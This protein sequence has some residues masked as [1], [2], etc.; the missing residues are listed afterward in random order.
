MACAS[1]QRSVS[2]RS[3]AEAILPHTPGTADACETHVRP[4]RREVY[5]Q[6]SPSALVTAAILPVQATDD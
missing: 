5:G 3:R 4:T 1:L 2:V 6:S